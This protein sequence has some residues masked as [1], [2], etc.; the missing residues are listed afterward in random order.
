M[1]FV[2]ALRARWQSAN[3]LLCVGLDPEPAKFPQRY[4]NDA[5]AVFAFCR[6]TVDAT[7]DLVCAFKPQF[8]HFAALGSDG[9]AALERIIAYIHAH[10]PDIPVILDAKR[11]DIGSTAAQY[12][13]EC[14]DRYGAD[15][16]TVNP[17]LGQDS[18]QPFLDRS[19]KGVIVLCRTSN[20]GAA[21]FQDLEVDGEALF[22]RVARAVAND[23][24]RA[25]NCALVVG[26]T[27]PAQLAQVRARVGDL[28]ILVPGIGTQGG[29]V[30]ATVRSGLD[31]AGTGLMVSASRSIL[32]A[33]LGNDHGEAARRAASSLREEI[34]RYR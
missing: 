29:G 32:Y 5:D 26:A 25:G 27:W 10:H 3:S 6:E 4:R 20:P 30:E 17:W 1:N 2:E 23:W 16:V 14:F 19:G 13:T 8:A 11:G 21:D 15:A 33:A 22:L 9:C 7:A 24:N 28:P 18:V 34:N 12:A 31:G